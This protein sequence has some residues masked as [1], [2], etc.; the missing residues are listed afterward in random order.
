VRFWQGLRDMLRDLWRIRR[1]HGRR[2]MVIG[3]S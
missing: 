3:H 2:K 1:L